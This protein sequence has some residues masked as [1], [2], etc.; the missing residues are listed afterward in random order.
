MQQLEA[1]IGSRNKINAA[2][3]LHNLLFT[4]DL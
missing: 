3:L 4:N 1:L 2:L